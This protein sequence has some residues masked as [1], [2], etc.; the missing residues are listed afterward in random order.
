MTATDSTISPEEQLRD[1]VQYC[2][3]QMAHAW[4]VRAFI[5]HSDEVEDFPELSLI[6]RAIFD[7]SR[8]LETRV[9][10]PIGYF[11]MLNKKLGKYRI[12]IEEFGQQVPEIST[13]TNFSQSV[14]SMQS[15]L[16]ALSLTLD[17][18]R[19]IVKSMA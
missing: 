17:Q 1:C 8:A 11:K 9:D 3:E 12:A 13:H 5:R 4:V 15:G 18:A 10:D 16:R 2:Q 14:I 6:C 19:E 7:L